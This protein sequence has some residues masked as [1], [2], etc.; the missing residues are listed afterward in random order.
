M[1]R[2]TKN[3]RNRPVL[4]VFGGGDGGGAIAAVPTPSVG[5]TAAGFGAV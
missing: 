3:R 2:L 4:F 1:I 5:V